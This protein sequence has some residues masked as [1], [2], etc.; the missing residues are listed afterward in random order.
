[1]TFTRLLWH[2]TNKT[3]PHIIYNGE[4][5]FMIQ[6][7][8][9]GYWGVGTYFAERAC[10]SHFYAYN[11]KD[12]PG[13]R[14]LFLAEVIVGE[15]I[16]LKPDRGL[17]VPPIK[18]NRTGSTDIAVERYD[19]VEG[20][21]GGSRVWIVYENNRGYPTYLVTYKGRHTSSPT[22]TTTTTANTNTTSTTTTTTTT[23][24]KKT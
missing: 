5:G 20:V 21:T 16:F 22:S 2:G 24:K 8:S 11:V 4:K 3:E 13:Y 7:A 17:R 6:H 14:Q 23:K 19:S 18:P 9:E 15:S 12:Q 1:L 10:Y